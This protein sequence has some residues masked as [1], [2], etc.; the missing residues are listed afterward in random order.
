VKRA[1][2]DVR[3]SSKDMKRD[4]V[5]EYIGKKK[6]EAGEEGDDEGSEEELPSDIEKVDN[7]PRKAK[8]V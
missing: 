7:Q 5:R 6:K 3:Y 8:S 4:A 1:H 2:K